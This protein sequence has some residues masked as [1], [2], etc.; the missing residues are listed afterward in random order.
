MKVRGGFSTAFV[1]VLL[2]VFIFVAR[3]SA[4]KSGD[5][6]E[7]RMP[8]PDIAA[9]I[10]A[11]PPPIVMNSAIHC[12]NSSDEDR[13]AALFWN[14]VVPQ[15]SG[16]EKKRSARTIFYV[17]IALASVGGSSLHSSQ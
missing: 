6:R 7:A 4:A 9:L 2:P 11:T 3:M 5:D 1:G 8:I 16:R 14:G 15:N 12:R 17:V 13:D 10:R